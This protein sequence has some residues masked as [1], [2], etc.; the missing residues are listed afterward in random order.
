MIDLNRKQ[1]AYRRVFQLMDGE[2]VGDVKIVLAD[3]RKF[4]GMG[5]APLVV[6]PVTVTTD[7]I[8]TGVSIG[9]QEVYRR[10]EAMLLMKPRARYELEQGEE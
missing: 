5:R 8:A 6:S 3:L 2:A 1:T 9:K 7:P 4:C 10:I